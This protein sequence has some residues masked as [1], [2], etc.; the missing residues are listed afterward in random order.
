MGVQGLWKLLRAAGRELPL[1]HLAGKTV[2]VDVSIWLTQF[3]KAMR[4]GEGNMLKNAHLLG[5]FRR[6]CKLLYYRIKPV[7]VF[8]G[9][10]PMRKR[11]TLAQRSRVK[12]KAR[13]SL[14]RTAEKLLIN[15]LKQKSLERLRDPAPSQVDEKHEQKVGSMDE[16]VPRQ[17]KNIPE[18]EKGDEKILTGDEKIPIGDEKVPAGDEKVLVEDEKTFA[19][20][21][22]ILGEEEGNRNVLEEEKKT[23]WTCTQ[24]TYRNVSSAHICSMC[25]ISERPV[26]MRR[27]GRGERRRRKQGLDNVYA[28]VKIDDVTRVDPKIVA[29][30][31]MSMQYDIMLE[32]I[33]KGR[34]QNSQRFLKASQSTVDY[35]K[36]QIAAFLN[37]SRFNQKVKAER[38]AAA[39]KVRPAYRMSSEGANRFSLRSGL[40][41]IGYSPAPLRKGVRYEDIRLGEKEVDKDERKRVDIDLT[42]P[43]AENQVEIDV[44]DSEVSSASP[45]HPDK[46]P[47]ISK[48]SSFTEDSGYIPKRTSRESL[49]KEK[50][51]NRG[52]SSGPISEDSR[53]VPEDSRNVTEDSGGFAG[54][55]EVPTSDAQDFIMDISDSSSS[56]SPPPFHPLQPPPPPPAHSV[57]SPPPTVSRS[58]TR[59]QNSNRNSNPNSKSKPTDLQSERKDLKSEKSPRIFSSPERGEG[60]PLL[61]DP[62][63]VISPF[64]S[65]SKTRVGSKSEIKI[66]RP[67]LEGGEERRAGGGGKSE[68]SGKKKENVGKGTLAA[69]KRKGKDKGWECP[70]CGAFNSL[71]TKFKIW[72]RNYCIGCNARRPPSLTFT[73][74]PRPPPGLLTSQYLED[75]KNSTIEPPGSPTIAARSQQ[76]SGD[77]IEILRDRSST[78]PRGSV[79]NTT[80]SQQISGDDIEI[81]EHPSSANPRESVKIIGGSR[82][83]SEDGIEILEDYSATKPR[84]SVGNGRSRQISGDDIEF[85]E[86]LSST[87]PR[88][89]IET[90]GGSPHV[91]GEDIKILEDYDLVENPAFPRKMRKPE[92]NPRNLREIPENHP[93]SPRTEPRESPGPR[94]SPEPREFP[95]RR[96]SS[97]PRKSPEIREFPEA[98]EPSKSS[99]CSEPKESVESR[100]ILNTLECKDRVE[101]KNISQPPSDYQVCVRGE[102]GK[103]L[104][105][106][107]VT[108]CHKT[109][110]GS[111]DVTVSADSALAAKHGI[112]GMCA[113]NVPSEFIRR[114]PNP[115]GKDTGTLGTQKSRIISRDSNENSSF[116]LGTQNIGTQAP[117]TQRAVSGRGKEKSEKTLQNLERSGKPGKYCE[118][119]ERSKKLGE[120]SKRRPAKSNTSALT[121][122]KSRKLA[123]KNK[124]NFSAARVPKALPVVWQVSVQGEE[125]ENIGWCDLTECH[126]NK[127]GSFNVVVSDNSELAK[128]H[129]IAGKCANDIPSAFIRKKP[130]ISIQSRD[131]HQESLGS[132]GIPQDSKEKSR[133]LGQESRNSDTDSDGSG[134]SAYTREK[135]KK[136]VKSRVVKHRTTK[137]YEDDDLDALLQDEED[138]MK[139]RERE[140]LEIENEADMQ[141][142]LEIQ[143]EQDHLREEAR[144]LASERRTQEGIA[145]KVTPQMVEEAKRLLTLFGIPY[146]VSPAEAEAQ[147]SQLLM[148]GLVD[149]ILTEDSDTF[150]FGGHCVY[151]NVF[152]SKKR[153]AKYTL[154]DIKKVLGLTRRE[155]I[156]IALL[157]GSDYTTG[158]HGV[159]IVN[160]LEILAAFPGPEGLKEFRQWVYS[161]EPAY[162]PTAPPE[163]SEKKDIL[164]YR[165]AYFKY[166]HRNIKASWEVSQNFPDPG[167]ISAYLHPNIDNNQEPFTWGTPKFEKVEEIC[168]RLFEWDSERTKQEVDPI[169]KAYTRSVYQ[170]TL[171]AFFDVYGDYSLIASKRLARSVRQLVTSRN[172]DSQVTNPSRN[173]DSRNPDISRNPETSRNPDVSRNPETSRNPDVARNPASSPKDHSNSGSGSGMTVLREEESGLRKRKTRDR[174]RR[175]SEYLYHELIGALVDLDGIRGHIT[176]ITQTPP[177]RDP[178]SASH[179]SSGD[180]PGV[181]REGFRDKA[182]VSLSGGVCRVRFVTGNNMVVSMLDLTV[183]ASAGENTSKMTVKQLQ[184]RLKSL[185]VPYSGL[186]SEL[187]LRLRCALA[188]KIASG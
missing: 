140:T 102:D 67:G 81:I 105:W 4:D 187:H 175:R 176:E 137:S 64:R 2:A 133:D 76:I 101:A 110:D 103:I 113:C 177:P 57:S 83:I 71:A 134:A 86:D 32:R 49:P 160:A 119:G 155:L 168:M 120:I 85:V 70:H 24:C 35:S 63:L 100:R 124:N 46:F 69:V 44:S 13:S 61:D 29:S 174:E 20:D 43:G 118:G 169:R 55:D 54:E 78:K 10:A 31:P 33:S 106:C 89:S 6:I 149:G 185:G 72:Q 42:S 39:N 99:E 87:K 108:E 127:N 28:G 59:T 115:A 34:S 145:A 79:M 178:P 18:I 92:R 141:R 139:E 167:I 23:A 161:A 60:F 5:I 8:D 62:I 40:K 170:S 146:V 111:F 41:N 181:S 95:E 121:K 68:K 38:Q 45:A 122:A 7:F 80:G 22:K 128:K 66:S 97:E 164:L 30:L 165:R 88:E 52:E 156:D 26:S 154:R 183:I 12:R 153:V 171:P 94:G 58:Q 9:P 123:K 15:Q 98:K 126:K 148:S 96:E 14:V 150:L 130:E 188:A 74:P 21:E 184:A 182:G 82:Q 157:V 114:K 142:N 36:Y 116:D 173:P 37:N 186:K 166:K 107:D 117:G 27:P 53:N 109:S 135:E 147:C 112:N 104:G 172:P 73:A 152:D 50:L 129:G 77:D 163:G 51:R 136:E 90:T 179:T 65:K 19:G 162:K 131:S 75:P 16:K 93:D 11:L 47:K 48:T 84:D 17:D 125:G 3:V 143:D 158:V 132:A 1:D 180:Q 56:P 159:G 138:V 91:S 151:K 144:K 25:G